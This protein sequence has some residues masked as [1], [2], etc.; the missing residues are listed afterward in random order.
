MDDKLISMGIEPFRN[1]RFEHVLLG[2]VVHAHLRLRDDDT[3]VHRREIVIACF[4]AIEGMFFLIKKSFLDHPNCAEIFSIHERAALS[5]ES[6]QVAR[7]G[8]VTLQTKYTPLPSMYKLIIRLAEK[9]HPEYRN[10]TID[11]R[12]WIGFLDAHGVRNRLTHPKDLDDLR[13]SRK[14]ANI[15]LAAVLRVVVLAVDIAT[16]NRQWAEAEISKLSPE[17]ANPFGD[18]DIGEVAHSD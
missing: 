16:L 2:D 15:C 18:G 1:D 8:R 14:E 3:E 9:I 5:E 17:F 12:S 13:V 11:S 4:S 7:T 6:Y 10:N